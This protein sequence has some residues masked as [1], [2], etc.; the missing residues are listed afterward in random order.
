MHLFIGGDINKCFV[1]EMVN[2]WF[3]CILEGAP[4]LPPTKIIGGTAATLGQF[5]HQAA[6][7]IDRETFCGGSLISEQWVLTAAHCTVSA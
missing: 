6:I 4:E 5:P 7:L 2:S 1:R 3:I